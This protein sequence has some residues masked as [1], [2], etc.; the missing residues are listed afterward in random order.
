MMECVCVVLWMCWGW[1]EVRGLMAAVCNFTAVLWS[2]CRL[3][4]LLLNFW[5]G[6]R[7]TIELFIATPD[8]SNICR[9]DAIKHEFGFLLH[10]LYIKQ[11]CYLWTCVFVVIRDG[12]IVMDRYSGKEVDEFQPQKRTRLYGITTAHAQCPSGMGFFSKMF[13]P[14]TKHCYKCVFKKIYILMDRALI[15]TWK[16]PLFGFTFKHECVKWC[17][18]FWL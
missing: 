13:S 9:F 1:S 11:C 4:A 6:N 5:K 15:W 10:V 8:M 16:N 12:V 3:S 2:S 17:H 7:V 14:V 18:Q